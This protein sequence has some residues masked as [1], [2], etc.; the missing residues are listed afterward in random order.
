MS[1]CS[2]RRQRQ[3]A[4]R[5]G[6]ALPACLPSPRL[7]V[8]ISISNETWLEAA[9]DTQLCLSVISLGEI[10]KG[11]A[12]LPEGDRRDQLKR[13]DEA[14]R[15]WFDGRILPVTE[16]I[17]ERWGMLAGECQI[18]GRPLKVAGD[19]IAATALEHDLT[20]VTRNVRDFS[21]LG[22]GILNPWDQ[23]FRS[24]K[25]KHAPLMRHRLLRPQTRGRADT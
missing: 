22:A 1:K 13:L 15:P 6:R 16:A 5:E 20:V 12:V 21:G 10:F 18:K 4:L 9:D 17:G 2:R 25:P 23:I 11:L 8:S 24:P 7:R 19:L 14:L 3:D